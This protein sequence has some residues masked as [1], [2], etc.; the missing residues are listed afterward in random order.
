[1]DKTKPLGILNTPASHQLPP[2]HTHTPT[3]PQIPTHTHPH[4]HIHTQTHTHAHTNTHTHTHTN[5][6]KKIT[7]FLGGNFSF[8]LTRQW[9]MYFIS[10]AKIWNNAKPLIRYMW[11]RKQFVV[12]LRQ[13]LYVNNIE[14]SE[15]YPVISN[16]PK[17]V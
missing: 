16:G 3:H 17:F 12:I 9:V 15:W 14:W 6:I 5:K 11:L 7:F 2:P 13:C 1:M 10:V 8:F 4:T